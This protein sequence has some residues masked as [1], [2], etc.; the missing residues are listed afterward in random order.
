MAVVHQHVP[1][2][3]RLGWMGIRFAVEKRVGVAAGAVGL[4]AQLDAAK[5]PLGSFPAGFWCSETLARARWRRRL[6]LLPVDPLQRGMGGQVLQQGAV[7]REV[8]FAEQRLTSGA[9]I[10]FLR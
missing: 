9:P 3:A 4:V 7:Y 10:S 2:T 8:L 5:I 1:P 6:I